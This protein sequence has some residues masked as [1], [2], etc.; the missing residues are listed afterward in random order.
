MASHHALPTPFDKHAFEQ[1]V[2]ANLSAMACLANATRASSSSRN[3]DLTGVP[4]QP[5]PSFQQLH[6]NSD[7]KSTQILSTRSSSPF[8]EASDAAGLSPLNG[9]FSQR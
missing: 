2:Q 4:T 6:L 5:S 8:S 7:N 1:I 9:E 3:P